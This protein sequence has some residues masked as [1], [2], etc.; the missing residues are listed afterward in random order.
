MNKKSGK[1]SE[2]VE[3]RFTFDNDK[4]TRNTQKIKTSDRSEV[5]NDEKK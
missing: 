1:S 2:N 5:M 4:L 3:K